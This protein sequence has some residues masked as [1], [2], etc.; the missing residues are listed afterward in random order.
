VTDADMM[1][2]PDGVMEHGGRGMVENEKSQTNKM[3]ISKTLKIKIPTV[4]KRI[5]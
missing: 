1:R 4:A 2:M 5:N 3:T